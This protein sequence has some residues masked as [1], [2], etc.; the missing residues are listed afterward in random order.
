R[1][2][3][4]AVALSAGVAVTSLA[5]VADAAPPEPSGPHPRI[6]LDAKRRAA[7]KES[8]RDPKSA[9]SRAVRQCAKLGA[10]LGREARNLYMGLDWAAHATNCALA[11][12]AT[13]DAAHAKTSIH[14]FTALL[15]DWVT[16]GDGKGGDAAA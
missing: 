3:R 1:G 8:A 15:D 13:G 11:W 12:H 7:L 6:L 2:V 10:D 14:F 9:T 5:A 4:G 16:V